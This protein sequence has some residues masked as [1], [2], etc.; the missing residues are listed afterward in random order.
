MG[1]YDKLIELADDLNLPKH[2]LKKSEELLKTFFGPS[3]ADASGMIADRVKLKRFKNQIKILEKAQ[4]FINKKG[5]DPKQLNLKVLAPM[6]EHSSLE[7]NESLQEKWS[8]LIANTLTEDRQV[9]LE[10]N[11]VNILSHIS[12]DEAILLDELLELAKKSRQE[13]FNKYKTSNWKP[14]HINVLEDIK[15][16]NVYL[17]KKNIDELI[18][19]DSSELEVLISGLVSLAVV[20]W[21]TPEVE[22]TASRYSGE[23]DDLDIDVDVNV[24]DPTG[25]YLTKLGIDFIKICE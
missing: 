16:T 12:P 11:C 5:L 6:I 15:L 10:Q 20:K 22:V 17:S 3:V 2:I 25:I 24:Y 23:P 21:E 13:R 7:E 18:D 8:K 14:K 4:E 1:K 9:R 19:L